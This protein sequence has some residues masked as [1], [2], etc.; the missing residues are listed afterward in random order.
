[1]IGGEG[2]VPPGRQ[3]FDRGWRQG[4]LFSVPPAQVAFVSHELTSD[5]EVDLHRRNVRQAERLVV[6]SQDCDIVAR[7]SDE[8]C[9][10]ALICAPENER[11]E[12]RSRSEADGTL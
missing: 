8:P 12:A 11:D 5:G 10:E 2:S 1:M 7:E 6:V 3:L 4:A 9:I